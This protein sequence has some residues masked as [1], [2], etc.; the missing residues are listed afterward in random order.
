MYSL[1][2]FALCYRL[3]SRGTK[4]KVGIAVALI[5]QPSIVFLD[6]ATA[7]LDPVSRRQ[8]WDVLNDYRQAG[9]TI[10]ITSQV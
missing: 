4:R 8:M 2:L 10:V 7:G 6:E 9:G 3:C 5:G 1:I